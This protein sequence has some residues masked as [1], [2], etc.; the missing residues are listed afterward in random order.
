MARRN[1]IRAA[2]GLALPLYRAY[3]ANLGR[4][5]S[6]D[7][8]GFM[9]GPNTYAYVKGNP[10]SNIDPTGLFVSAVHNQMTRDAMAMAGGVRCPRL[11]QDVAL[12][13]YEE[14][15]QDAR[16]AFMHALLDATDSSETHDTA[17]AKWNN[18]VGA[19]MNLCTCSGLAHALHAWQDSEAGGHIG[20]PPY[21]GLLLGWIPL[22]SPW[23]VWQDSWPNDNQRNAGVNASRGLIDWFNEKCK[24]T[25]SSGR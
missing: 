5:I 24:C 11:P 2:S 15:S 22:V 4:W 10:T 13:D 19:Q 8:M 21:S 12:V 23:H 18:Y 16:N 6:E 14:G 3:D 1:A 25:K 17:V 9:D 7:P 20:F